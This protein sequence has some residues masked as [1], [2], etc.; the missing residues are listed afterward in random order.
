MR[1]PKKKGDVSYL[2]RLGRNIQIERHARE[3]SQEKMAEALEISNRNY[4]R[5]EAGDINPSATTLARIKKILGCPWNHLMP[6]KD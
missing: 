5:I 1:T 3:L 6:D 4:Q 2:I